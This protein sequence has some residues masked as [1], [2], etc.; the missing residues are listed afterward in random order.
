MKYSFDSKVFDEAVTRCA[1]V[2]DGYVIQFTN[3]KAGDDEVYVTLSAST[4]HTLSNITISAV[5]DGE[6]KA[7]QVMVGVDFG[8][9]V[10]ALAPAGTT[11][12]LDIGTDSAVLSC[13]DACIPIKYLS[14]VTKL[15]ICSPKTDEHASFTIET[16]EWKRVINQGGFAFGE[17]ESTGNSAVLNNIFLL[18]CD[19][20][21]R[22]VTSEGH[23]AASS[24]A[25]IGTW[26]EK[27]TDMVKSVQGVCIPPASVKLINSC[28]KG[29]AITV[30]LFQNQLLIRDGNDVFVTIL[31]N[32]SY[33]MNI[34]NMLASNEFEYSFEAR[35]SDIKVALNIV[36]VSCANVN[37][38][39]MSLSV[40]ADGVIV[41][42]K[43]NGNKASI[44]N[45]NLTGNTKTCV[46]I[47]QLKDLV[48]A[49]ATEVD[50]VTICGKN[51]ANPIFVKGGHSVSLTLPILIS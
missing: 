17:Y 36:S 50:S 3:R 51:G 30:C 26:N 18:P 28:L 13:G 29:E 8:A 2:K 46:S 1:A 45:K 35:V 41:V 49:A 11:I 16:K 22:V 23:F 15:K 9:A 32:N 14:Q 34:F 33:P 7:M 44:S 21:I 19:G 6:A 5:P 39:T 43:D 12:E 20:G 38:A 37:Q 40:S 10:H 4:T 42:S 48:S 25:T 47:R 31:A 24:S 27:F